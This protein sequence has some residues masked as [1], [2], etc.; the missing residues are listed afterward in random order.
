MASLVPGKSLST[1]WAIMWAAVCRRISRASGSVIVRA[2]TSPSVGRGSR[3][4]R[5]SPSWRAPTI[6]SASP[7]SRRSSRRLTPEA[8]MT[9]PC[10]NTTLAIA[11]PFTLGNYR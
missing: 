11:S 10:G 3:M 9:S 2:F 5:S 4:S 8:S 6:P 1:A 7:L